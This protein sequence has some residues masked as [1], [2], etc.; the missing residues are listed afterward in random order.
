[1]Y[2]LAT[3]IILQFTLV[4]IHTDSYLVQK[5]RINLSG[6][7]RYLTPAHS[8]PHISI[9]LTRE[10]ESNSELK[11]LLSRRLPMEHYVLNEIPCINFTRGPD[12]SRLVDELKLADAIVVTSPRVSH[13]QQ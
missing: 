6:L 13:M 4:T 12:I 5:N 1:M 11:E 9:A 2:L 10:T 8:N 3:Y 7:H